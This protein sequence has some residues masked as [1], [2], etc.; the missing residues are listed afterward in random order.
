MIALMLKELETYKSSK[1]SVRPSRIDLGGDESVREK[2]KLNAIKTIQSVMKGHLERSNS[3][4]RDRKERERKDRERDEKREAQLRRTPS[5]SPR[6]FDSRPRSETP[7][8]NR[9]RRDSDDDDYE[10]TPRRPQ[11][12]YKRSPPRYSRND[13][14]ESDDDD[15]KR[16]IPKKSAETT[17]G[18]CCSPWR[19]RKDK[20]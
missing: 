3:V 12:A 2:H 9:R 15:D 8:L 5:P 19:S 10:E 1:H 18:G 17:D 7:P 6:R 20:K 16:L 14:D 4:K 13:Y 11:T